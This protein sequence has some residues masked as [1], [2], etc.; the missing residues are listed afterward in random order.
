MPAQEFV[1]FSDEELVEFAGQAPEGDLRAFDE[2][3]ERYRRRIMANCEHITRRPNHSEDLA[4]EIFVKIYFA[5]S[6]FEGRSSFRN[7]MQKIK[8]N[9]CLNFLK[10]L[11]GRIYLDIDDSFVLEEAEQKLGSL[12]DPPVDSERQRQDVIAVLHALPDGLRIPLIMCDMDGLSYEEI[13]RVLV[14]SLSATKMRIS[15]AREQFRKRY[16]AL[17]A[18]QQNHA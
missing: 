15:R 8:V 5:L 10:R 13:S 1:E 3:I 4:Q 17:E 12:H 6:R 14:I 2:L 11:N 18:R 16:R 9:H 7:W